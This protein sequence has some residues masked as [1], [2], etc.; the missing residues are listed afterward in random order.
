MRPRALGIDALWSLGKQQARVS[1]YE[2]DGFRKVKPAASQEEGNTELRG[3]KEE[4]NVLK[5]R[6][7]YKRPWPGPKVSGWDLQAPCCCP[8]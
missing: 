5:A 3:T 2:R 7:G 6:E 8:H 4:T 1:E